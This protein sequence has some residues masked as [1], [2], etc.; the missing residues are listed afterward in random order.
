MKVIA[1]ERGHTKLN[2]RPYNIFELSPD[3]TSSSISGICRTSS[4]VL[5][6]GI[7]RCADLQKSYQAGI[8]DISRWACQELLMA[9]RLWQGMCLMRQTDDPTVPS[10]HEV[11][12]RLRLLSRWP[13]PTDFVLYQ[14]SDSYRIRYV[15]KSCVTGRQGGTNGRLWCSRY[16]DI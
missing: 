16:I 8:I 1:E 14:L 3:I 5:L 15:C 11:A 13:V 6:V 4:V 10:C 9:M 12:V 7:L 2:R